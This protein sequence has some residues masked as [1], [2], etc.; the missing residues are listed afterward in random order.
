MLVSVKVG[1]VT[2]TP[3]ALLAVPLTQLDSTRPRLPARLRPLDRLVGGGI[4]AALASGDFTG[5]A[6]QCTLLYPTEAGK[7]TRVLLVGLGERAEVDAEKLR[8]AAGISAGRAASSRARRMAIW[9]PPL[10]RLKETVSAQALTEGAMLGSYNFDLYRE[11]RKDA[12]EA[13]RSLSLVYDKLPQAGEVRRAASEGKILA[14]CQNLA[15]LLSDQPPNE[16]SP[17]ALAK[18]A[19]RVAREVGLTSRVMGPSELERHEMRGLLAVGQGS[20]NSPRLVVLE[21]NAPQRRGKSLPTLCIVGKGITFD[22]GGISIKPASD[23][24]KMKHDMSGAAAVIGIMRAAA[25]LELPLHLVGIIAAAENLPGGSAYRPGDIV[26]TMSGKTV[27]VLNTDAEGR[28]VL[29]DALHHAQS[30]WKPEA[31]LDLAT[32]TGACQVALGPWATGLF[33]NDAALI[34]AVRRAGE[35]TGEIAWPMPLFEEHRKEMRSTS[36]DL[37]NAGGRHAGASTAAAFLQSFVGEVPWVHLDIAGTGWTTKASPYQPLGAT[38]V[39]VRLTVELLR[40]WERARR[41]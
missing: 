1:D 41:N 40:S 29:A 12:P 11:K 35:T 17:A 30:R 28:I 4:T 32:L 23:M 10:G 20:A 38:G 39:G 16:L 3:S 9:V 7:L 24:D 6:E 14:D 34:E 25:L 33:G 5:R 15:R 2:R 22:S 36:A 21:H 18:Q 13:P 26:R 27:E 19:R 8:R 31:M 37:K